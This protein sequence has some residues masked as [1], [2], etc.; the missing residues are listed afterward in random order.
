LPEK[1]TCAT[2]TQSGCTARNTGCT[3]ANA[4]GYTLNMTFETTFA[5]DG[6]SATGIATI[7]IT[8]HGQSCDETYDVSFARQ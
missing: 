7:N 8:G 4:Q 1:I 6:S 3:G 5:A 2:A